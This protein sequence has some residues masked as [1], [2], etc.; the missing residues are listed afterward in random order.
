VEAC[1]L[2]RAEGGAWRFVLAGSPDEGNPSSLTIRELQELSD[3]H[4][5]EWEGHSREIKRVLADSHIV[6]LPSYR[7]GLPKILLEAAATGRPLIATDV[8]GCREVVRS[9]RNGFLV[10]VRSPESIA[11]AIKTLA[12]AE[13]TMR[14]MG[15]KSRQLAE[16]EFSLERIVRETFQVYDALT[17]NDWRRSDLTEEACK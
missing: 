2:L 3:S 7:E 16:N 8:P 13:E 14:E 12:E 5:V 11:N 10:P 4:I 17:F 1:R 15:K 6:C 9:G